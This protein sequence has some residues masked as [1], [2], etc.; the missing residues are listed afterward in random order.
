MT[1]GS[2]LDLWQQLDRPE[3]DELL[4]AAKTLPREPG[5]ADMARLRALA[6]PE[7]VRLAISLTEAR[8][9]LTEKW[10]EHPGPWWSDVAGAEQASS[11]LAACYKG[12][13][14][15][16]RI[17]GTG[18]SLEDVAVLDLACGIGAD[19][20][21][22]KLAGLRC[23]GWDVDPS[24]AWMMGR[25]TAMPS[26]VG[27]VADCA[28]AGRFLHVDPARRADGGRIYRLADYQ[29]GPE[30]LACLIEQSDGGVMKLGPGLDLA[31]LAP[32][33]DRPMDVELLSE[34]GRLTQLLL[35]WGFAGGE[36]RASDVRR[37]TLLGLGREPVTLEAKAGGDWVPGD[38]GR[39]V[40]MNR[41]DWGR[42]VWTVDAAVERLGLMAVLADSLGLGS[43]LAATGLLTGD[44]P[45][46]SPW[47][48]GFKVLEV[49]PWRP[50]GLR[51]RL[52]QLGAGVV[53]VKCRGRLV[54]TDAMQAMLR[55]QGRQALTV[56]AVRLGRPVQALITQ[57]MLPEC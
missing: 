19:S 5:P 40:G 45:V 27:D 51:K 41:R 32:L 11:A 33:W 28:V 54:D 29:P 52:A 43:P 15:A 46:R 21:G 2:T 7:L 57:R 13:E 18:A 37:A 47:L 1:H 49:L 56:F 26:V 12:R 4:R 30:V 20:L 23:E 22:M 38:R 3:A 39:S 25:N 34:S 50:A 31:E 14:L 24:R 10:P 42:Y 8:R 53:E 36:G 9:K 16:R 55:G 17:T 44:T 48:T 6:D 35:W